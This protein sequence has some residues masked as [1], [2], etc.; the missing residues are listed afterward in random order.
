METQ[1]VEGR[2]A[3]SAAWHAIL[4]RCRPP[5]A[6]S[7]HRGADRGHSVKESLKALSK[8]LLYVER[9]GEAQQAGELD[10]SWRCVGALGFRFPE[11]K[12][13]GTFR[14]CRRL[15]GRFVF[16]V[17]KG[18]CLLLVANPR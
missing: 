16:N 13:L 18:S 1:L 6:D 4:A 10:F 7:R 9:F 5:S 14:E 8:L 11:R 15:E 12:I 17:R 2:G 3:S